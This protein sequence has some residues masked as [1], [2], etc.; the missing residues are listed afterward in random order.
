MVLQCSLAPSAHLASLSP[1]PQSQHWCDSHLL[2]TSC[3]QEKPSLPSDSSTRLSPLPPAPN[4]TLNASLYLS[5]L[6]N[7]FP[8]LSWTWHS[9]ANH[10]VLYKIAGECLCACGLGRAL[11]QHPANLSCSSSLSFKH[12][13][14]CGR[15]FSR[16]VFP[17]LLWVTNPGVGCV[18]VAVRTGAWVGEQ[19]GGG[20]C[21]QRAT[22]LLGEDTDNCLV[23]V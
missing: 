22:G 20:F 12:H 18:F 8:L 19:D 1:F 15:R 13:H 16:E 5:V 10:T 11:Q 14:V 21:K 4:L 7:S 23:S 6:P 17:V 3:P 9:K 2:C